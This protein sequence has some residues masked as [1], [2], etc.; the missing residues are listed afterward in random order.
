MLHVQS[1]HSRQL[2]GELFTRTTQTYNIQAFVSHSPVQKHLPASLP[3]HF[4]FN[5]L[6]GRSR[7]PCEE[8]IWA[9]GTTKVDPLLRLPSLISLLASV[10]VKQHRRRRKLRLGLDQATPA[11]RHALSGLT[12]REESWPLLHQEGRGVDQRDFLP[13]SPRRPAEW[14]GCPR[15]RHLNHSGWDGGQLDGGC[16]KS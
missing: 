11:T 8:D 6:I 4:P 15:C 7:V 16:L 13:R 14:W 12:S 9:E 2:N 5:V 3:A 1:N 10:D